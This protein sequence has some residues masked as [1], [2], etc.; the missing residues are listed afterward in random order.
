[1]LTQE[2]DE[3]A[4]RAS[5]IYARR[6]PWMDRDD[7]YQEAWR[8]ALGYRTGTEPQVWRVVVLGLCEYITSTSHPVGTRSHR[9][10]AIAGV[11][12]SHTVPFPSEYRPSGGHARRVE[13]KQETEV[14]DALL[15]EDVVRELEEGDW[16]ARIAARLADLLADLPAAQEVLLG[17]ARPADVARRRRLPIRRIYRETYEARRR[18]R[19]CPA[20]RALWGA[21]R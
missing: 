20:L 16:C 4:K 10:E 7:L 18:L 5:G 21:R 6:V 9:R 19:A 12:A 17:E 2:I 1:M 11:R 15:C 14:L 13:S 8:L 3:L